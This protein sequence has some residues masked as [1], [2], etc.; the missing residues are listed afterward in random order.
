MGCRTEVVEVNLSVSVTIMMCFFH[1]MYYVLSDVLCAMPC[2]TLR[3]M[4]HSFSHCQVLYSSCQVNKGMCVYL[5]NHPRDLLTLIAILQGKVRLQG[6]EAILHIS[7]HMQILNVGSLESVAKLIRIS[8]ISFAYFHAIRLI[9]WFKL[10]CK[11]KVVNMFNKV[12]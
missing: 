3:S 2:S 1:A 10:F 7:L 9:F 12:V 5:A 8:A 6:L 11:T 4:Q